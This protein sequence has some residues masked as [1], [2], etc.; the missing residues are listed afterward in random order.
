M[1]DLDDWR[2]ARWR[3]AWD[4]AKKAQNIAD[5]LE[6]DRDDP[7]G[8]E[9]GLAVVASWTAFCNADEGYRKAKEKEDA[10]DEV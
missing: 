6:R 10:V 7:I 9:S 3:A 5:R 4:H 2:A 1:T 8:I